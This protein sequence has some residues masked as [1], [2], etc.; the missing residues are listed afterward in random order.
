MNTIK[1]VFSFF[2]LILVASC[3]PEPDL[4]LPPTPFALAKLNTFDG[5]FNLDDLVNSS[6]SWEVEFYDE[7]DGSHVTEYVWTVAYQDQSG[8]GDDRPETWIATIPK[9]EFFIHPQSGLPGTSRT[10]TF[11]AVLDVFG[12]QPSEINS[13]DIFNFSATLKRDNGI[14]YDKDNQGDVDSS[15]SFDGFFEFTMEVI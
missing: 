6:V 15:I 7:E 11:Q 12:M 10:W 13:G 3:K 5:V 1:I 8:G 2:I 4:D 9:S 14:E